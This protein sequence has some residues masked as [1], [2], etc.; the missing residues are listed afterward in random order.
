MAETTP[1]GAYQSA[2]GTWHDANGK[3]IPPPPVAQVRPEP[4]PDQEPEIVI[5]VVQTAGDEY[6]AEPE[7]IPDADEAPEPIVKSKK[8]RKGKGG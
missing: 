6:A 7:P 3:R 4:P 2:D 1:G 8:T 5:P